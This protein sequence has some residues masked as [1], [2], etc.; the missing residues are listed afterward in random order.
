[1]NPWV[2]ASLGT[3]GGADLRSASSGLLRKPICVS[4]VTGT[5]SPQLAGRRPAP[6]KSEFINRLYLIVMPYFNP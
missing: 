1:M 6:L 5:E 3:N 2:D 4:P